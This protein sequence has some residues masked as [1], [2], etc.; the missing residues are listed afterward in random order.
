[1]TQ[2]L[3]NIT[4]KG[5]ER[6]RA[7]QR[8][9]TEAECDEDIKEIQSRILG[10]LRRDIRMSMDRTQE[11]IE[12]MR[13]MAKWKYVLKSVLK[14]RVG[15]KHQDRLDLSV[16][17]TRDGGVTATDRETHIATT[18]GFEKVFDMQAIHREG[19]HTDTDWERCMQDRRSSGL[20]VK[21]IKLTP[22]G[23][24]FEPRSAGSRGANPKV[25]SRIVETSSCPQT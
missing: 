21:S 6:R 8:I 15:R 22:G 16:V 20:V 13:A 23:S 9:P 3:Y 18:L 14:D 10:R 7:L 25:A 12:K 11:T 17:R 5:P 19:L 4:K 24:W 1:M 2:Q